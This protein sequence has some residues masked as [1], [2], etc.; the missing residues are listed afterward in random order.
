VFPFKVLLR[1]S[2]RE[3]EE[4]YDK[5]QRPNSLFQKIRNIL[6]AIVLKLYH[7]ST[8]PNNNFCSDRRIFSLKNEAENSS[9]TLV[10]TYR[11]TWHHNLQD[12]G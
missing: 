12:R 10:T 7:P 9:E 11:T 5:D 6:W 8:S 3:T 2:L 1:N 4:I